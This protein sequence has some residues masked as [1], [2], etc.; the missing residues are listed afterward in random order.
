VSAYLVEVDDTKRGVHSPMIVGPFP[1]EDAAR[2]FAKECEMGT[3]AESDGG[4]S[5]VHVVSDETCDQTPEEYR[6]DYREVCEDFRALYDEDE[7]AQR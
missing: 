1:D 7:E 5:A 6:E 2:A 3:S 4:Y